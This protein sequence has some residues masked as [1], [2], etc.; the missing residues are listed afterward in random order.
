MWMPPLSIVW[1]PMYRV[2]MIAVDVGH[3][4]NYDPSAPIDEQWQSQ[5]SQEGGELEAALTSYSPPDTGATSD[6]IPGFPGDVFTRPP[7]DRNRPM[8]ERDPWRNCRHIVWGRL[9]ARFED[10][11]R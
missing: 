3:G 8:T 1:A 5:Q 6:L 9:R 4:L 7:A 11:S 2:M 10:V